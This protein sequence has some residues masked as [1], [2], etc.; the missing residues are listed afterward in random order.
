[1][2]LATNISDFWINLN[3]WS[4]VDFALLVAVMAFVFIF[5]IKRNSVKLAII[6]LGI[7]L[8]FI[9][10]TVVNALVGKG[11]FA[12]A[13]HIC[14]YVMIATIVILVTVYRADFKILVNSIAHKKAQ[15]GK[16]DFKTSDDKLVAAASEIVKACQNMAK[17][18]IGALIVIAPTTVSEH[19]L[20]TGTEINANLSSGLIESLFFTKSPLHDGAVIVKGDRIIS[21]GCFLPLTADATIDKE[22]G[23]RHRAAIGVTEE[24]DVTAVV[25][26]EETGIISTVTHGKMKRYMTPDKLFEEIKRAFGVVSTPLTERKRDKKFL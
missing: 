5:F 1:M 3:W 15:S 25:V 22:L 4:I 10:L 13:I 21:A 26:S 18:D 23:T 2:V 12:L 7:S 19:I 9:G 20:E 16:F 17:N 14:N 8:V 11:V 24:S 6:V